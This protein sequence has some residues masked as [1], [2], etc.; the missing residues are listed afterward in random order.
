MICLCYDEE[1][2]EC[3]G[4]NIKRYLYK[5]KVVLLHTG[6]QVVDSHCPSIGSFACP[7][8]LSRHNS[9]QQRP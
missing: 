9:G 8:R 1:N 4:L 7:S 3:C 6:I 5:T 2:S